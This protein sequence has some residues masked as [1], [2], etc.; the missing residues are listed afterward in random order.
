MAAQNSAIVAARRSAE[1]V[2]SP[3]IS[4]ANRAQQPG[5][6]NTRSAQCGR[7]AAAVSATR[8]APAAAAEADARA[9]SAQS[10]GQVPRRACP[11]ACWLAPMRSRPPSAASRATASA[12]R[13]ARG[14]GAS[15]PD[16]AGARQSTQGQA[17]QMRVD[18]V[19]RRHT[20]GWPTRPRRLASWILT[21]RR[22]AARQGS[23]RVCVGQ[24]AR[25][26]HST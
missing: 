22:A 3:A 16:C 19:G 7:A 23:L 12:V 6:L 24:S 8:Q 11:R 5:V 13:S 18:P 1:A 21:R 15:A 9:E 25:A 17:I 20:P 26:A 4:K 2:A 14:C 10:P